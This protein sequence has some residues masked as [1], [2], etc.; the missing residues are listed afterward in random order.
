MSFFLFPQLITSMLEAAVNK[1]YKL[2]PTFAQRSSPLVGKRLLVEV[3]EAKVPLTFVV[4]LDRFNV[5]SRKSEENDCAIK[6]SLAA[7]KELND[8]NQITRLIKDGQLSLTGDLHVAQQFSQLLKETDIDWEEHLSEYLGDGLAHKVASRFRHFGQLLASKNQDFD[9][10]ITE[11]S[12]DEIN[13]APH[14]VAVVDHRQKVNQ[15][16]AK[17]DKLAARIAKM[18]SRDR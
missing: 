14:P 3:A 2:D 10:I 17:V 12:Q 6:T 7:L 16:R 1:L 13:V 8:P 5:L 18:S 15:T 9:R 4:G 11:F